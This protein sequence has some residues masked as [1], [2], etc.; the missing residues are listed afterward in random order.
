MKEHIILFRFVRRFSEEQAR[1]HAG[2]AK[3]NYVYAGFSKY[4]GVYTQ[5]SGCVSSVYVF[6]FDLAVSSCCYS[7]LGSESGI[8]LLLLC[9]GYSYQRSDYCESVLFSGKEFG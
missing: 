6:Y 7:I 8:R 3:G 5:V 9:F 1:I 2:S 4:R